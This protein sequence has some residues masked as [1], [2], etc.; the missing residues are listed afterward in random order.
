MSI[1]HD[2]GNVKQRGTIR[3]KDYSGL[4]NDEHILVLFFDVTLEKYGKFLLSWIESKVNFLLYRVHTG[5]HVAVCTSVCVFAYGKIVYSN[6][7]TA[8]RTTFAS[9]VKCD[10]KPNEFHSNNYI[11]H[12]KYSI[13]RSL[14]GCIFM[15]YQEW[16]HLKFSPHILL[17]DWEAKFMGKSLQHY[18]SAL[19]RIF[20]RPW[21]VCW[22]LFL[23]L[24]LYYYYFYTINYHLPFLLLDT[25]K[26]VLLNDTLAE[27]NS[28][29]PQAAD[30]TFSFY[31]CF[32]FFHTLKLQ[33]Q[34][35]HC[36][37]F[38]WF[39][40]LFIFLIRDK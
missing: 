2:R 25:R 35:R 34:D 31:C 19:N 13:G 1:R 3:K 18:H 10:T 7:K 38:Y 39:I 24:F 40:Y 23:L 4:M 6:E 15:Q 12:F 32:P 36:R 9:I 29:F 33:C 16:L 17:L 5:K 28:R 20:M 37:L 8:L 22:P 30:Q 11:R 27:D 14:V 21:S 26:V